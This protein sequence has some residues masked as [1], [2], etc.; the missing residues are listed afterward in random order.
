MARNFD[1]PMPQEGRMAKSYLYAIEQ[2]ARQ[3]RKHLQ[4][5]DDLPGWVQAKIVTAQ[6]RIQTVNRYMG[7]KIARAEGAIE[8]PRKAAAMGGVLLLAGVALYFLSKD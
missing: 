7:H 8:N 3:L 6:D 5:S 1:Y 2:D 4:D